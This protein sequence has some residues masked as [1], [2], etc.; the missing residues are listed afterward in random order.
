ML[1]ENILS[2]LDFAFVIAGITACSYGLTYLYTAG[3]LR[4]FNV[5]LYFMEVNTKDIFFTML[6]L[7]PIIISVLMNLELSWIF[8]KTPNDTTSEV[9]TK[10]KS[11]MDEETIKLLE[12]IE[13]NVDAL[14]KKVKRKN[15]KTLILFY[16]ISL[17]IWLLIFYL[18]I[19]TFKYEQFLFFL[20]TFLLQFYSAIF[21]SYFSK[22][23][24]YFKLT[25]TV[26]IFSLSL[27]FTSGWNSSYIKNN[28]PIFEDNDVTYVVL[29][30]YKDNFV[31]SVLDKK[32]KEYKG[33]M[34]LKEIKDVKN[35]FKIESIGFIKRKE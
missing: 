30:F 27:S 33:D 25:L 10:E 20:I 35:G 11:E 28:Y 6:T 24:K 16:F 5:P 15:R 12:T 19:F 2:K 9:P 8:K 13:S 23:K 34:H 31:Y 32:N 4:Y 26:I 29:A 1:K 7:S 3:Q 21:V 17:A 18:V 14:L 22:R